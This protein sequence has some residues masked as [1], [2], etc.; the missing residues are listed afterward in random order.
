MKRSHIEA[1]LSAADGETAA[2]TAE[3]TGCST[4]WISRL[5]A[6]ACDELKARN[7]THA[8]ALACQRGLFY[9]ENA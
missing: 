3:R 7:I 6:E 9:K 1:L 2:E 8:V 4:S 5:R